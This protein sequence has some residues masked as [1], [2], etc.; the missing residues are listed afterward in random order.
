[1][2]LTKENSLKL[3]H[4]CTSIADALRPLLNN[5]DNFKRVEPEYW[6]NSLTGFQAVIDSILSQPGLSLEVNESKEVI[7]G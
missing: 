6:I 1:M 5:D 3:Y 2:V 4:Y 7:N